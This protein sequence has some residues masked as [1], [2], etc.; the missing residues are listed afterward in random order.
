VGDGVVFEFTVTLKVA[1][2]VPLAVT[3]RLC[4]CAVMVGATFTVRIAGVK[5]DTLFPWESVTSA[6]T[7]R[8]VTKGAEPTGGV[9]KVD[10]QGD[11]VH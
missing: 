2:L 11:V 8:P 4:G 9:V 3:V 1:V 10:E 5:V 6:T 7:S